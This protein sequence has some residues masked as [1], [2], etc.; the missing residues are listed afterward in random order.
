MGWYST[1]IIVHR[2]ESWGSGYDPAAAWFALNPTTGTLQELFTGNEQ[3]PAPR[4]RGPPPAL[5]N[6]P[7]PVLINGMQYG[8]SNPLIE[9]AD[10][11]DISPDGAHV[12][13][14][15]TNPQWRLRER[16]PQVHH[17]DRDCRRSQPHRSTQFD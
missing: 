5:I 1:G 10:P 2:V 7:P 17:R 11:A 3:H 4:K 12:A 16:Q 13:V 15:R 14:S 9:N 6:A 8:E